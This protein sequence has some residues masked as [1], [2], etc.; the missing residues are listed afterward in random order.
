MTVV[1][2]N[3]SIKW[4]DEDEQEGGIDDELSGMGGGMPGMGGMDALGA[5]GG[6]GNIG[7]SLS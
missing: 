7:K 4:V 6:F 3:G 5:D 1:V 2:F